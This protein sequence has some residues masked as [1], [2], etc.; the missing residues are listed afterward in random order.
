MN[1][2]PVSLLI[3]ASIGLHFLLIERS[4]ADAPRYQLDCNRNSG[5][6]FDQKFTFNFDSKEASVLASKE[7]E[8]LWINYD[9]SSEIYA[10]CQQQSEYNAKFRATLV[11]RFTK[12]RKPIASQGLSIDPL[13]N[14]FVCVRYGKKIGYE[15]LG[16]MVFSLDHSRFPKPNESEF[17]TLFLPLKGKAKDANLGTPIIDDQKLA[18]YSCRSGTAPAPR[19]IDRAMPS[20]D[21]HSFDQPMPLGDAGAP[22]HSVP[23]DDSEDALPMPA[24]DTAYEIDPLAE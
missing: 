12:S 13:S 23:G 8:P 2:R 22:A 19:P 14:A 15:Y 9:E 18:L 16:A 10:Y 1:P 17:K 21:D 4:P 3:L 7:K 24:G 6:A 11:K 20:E 5:T